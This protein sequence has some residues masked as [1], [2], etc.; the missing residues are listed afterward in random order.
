[1]AVGRITGPLL[2]KN[3]VRDGVDIAFDTDLLY[4][5][6]TNGRIGIKQSAPQYELDVSGT[7][8]ADRLIVNTA[9]IGLVT[10]ESSTSTNTGSTF[11]TLYGPIYIAPSGQ[12][13]I[14]LNANTYVEGSLHATGDITA[15]GDIRLGNSSTVDTLVI[16]AEV[17]SDIIPNL[18]TGTFVVTTG[19]STVFVTNTNIVSDFNIGSSSS[20]WNSGFFENIYGNTISPAG[21]STDITVFPNPVQLSNG[22][23]ANALTING[24]IRVYGGNPLG[25]APVVSNVLYVTMDGNDDNDGRAEDATRACRTVSGATQSPYYK[26]GTVIKVRSGHYYENNPI[27][28]LPYTAVIGDDLRTTFLE[29]INKTVDLFHV[30]SGVYI[31]QMNFLNLRRG[32]VTRYTPGGA[33]TYTTGAYCVAFPPRLDNPIDIYYSPYVQNCTNQSGPWMYDGTMF[34]PNQTVQIPNVVAHSTYPIGTDTIVVT[35]ITGTTEIIAVGDAVNGSGATISAGIPYAVVTAIKNT[36]VSFDNARILLEENK[37]FI[38]EEVLLYVDATNPGFVYDQVKCKRDVGLIL[39]AI[40]HDAILGGNEKSVEAGLSYYN[41]N[42]ILIPSEVSTTTNAIRYIETLANLVVGNEA[43]PI[44]YQ[45]VVPQYINTTTDGGTVARPNITAAVDTII[46]IIENWTVVENASSLLTANRSFIQAEVVAY[47]DNTFA[48]GFVYDKTKC[49]RDVGLIVES[50][51]LDLLY[52]GTSQSKFTGLQYWAQSSTAIPNEQTTTTNAINYAKTLAEQIVVNTTGVRYQSTVSQVLDA[53]NPGDITGLAAEFDL[54]TSIIANGTTGTT[55]LIVANGAVSASTATIN[56]YNLLVANR[57]F[58]QSEVVAYVEN[59][60]TSGFT[61]NEATCGRDVGYIIDSVAFDILHG[62]NRQAIQSGVYYYN[63]SGVTNA[64]A[65][66]LFQINATYEYL[67]TVI[68]NVVKATVIA[69]PYQTSVNQ[70]LGAGATQVE[71][72]ALTS[73]IDTI[74]NIIATGPSVAGTKEAI[75]LSASTDPNIS[76]AVA[77]LE[78]NKNFIRNEIIAYVDTTFPAV[79]FTYNKDF[80]YRDVGLIVDAVQYDIVHKSNTESIRAGKSYWN[81]ATSLIP[82]ESPQTLAAIAYAKELASSVVANDPVMPLQQTGGTIITQVINSQL[83]GGAIVDTKLRTAFDTISIIV[84][85]GISAAPATSNSTA[86]QFTIVLS[87]STVATKN[88]DTL[89][90]GTTYV[91]PLLDDEVPTEWSTST[92]VDRRLDPHGSGGGALVDGFA[93]S[94]KSPIQSFVFDAFTQITQGGN[95]IHIINNGYA[96][97]VSVFTIFC[98]IAVHCENG[99][100]CSI[101]NSNSNFGDLCLVAEGYG[102]REFGGTIYNPAIE[103][104]PLGFY[105]YNQEVEVFVPDAKNRPHIALVMEVIPP[106]TYIDYDLNEVQYVNEQG[107]P[108]FLSAAANSDVLTTSSYVITPIDT[109]GMAI[110]Q[111]IYI[112]DQYGN[113]EDAFGH[114][115]TTT[116][117]TITAI[118][119]QKIT[120]SEPITQ[121]GGEV[122]N[123]NYFNIYACG[124]AYYNILSSVKS[125]DKIPPGQSKIKGQEIQ[126]IAAIDYLKTLAQAVVSNDAIIIP[127]QTSTSQIIDLAL[128]GS[129]AVGA[130]GTECDIITGIILTGPTNAPTVKTSGVIPSGVADAVTL[131]NKNRKFIQDEV[132]AYVDNQYVLSG[133]VY[134]SVKCERDTGLIV[135]SLAFDL[136][137]EGS[138]QSTFAGLQYWTQTGPIDAIP[139]EITTTTN[140]VLHIKSIVSSIMLSSAVDPRPGNSTLQV[141]GTAGSTDTATAAFTNVGTVVTILSTGVGGIT[142]NIVSNGDASVDPLVTN[143]YDLLL[144]NKTFIIDDTIAWINGNNSGFNYNETTCRRDVG[145][146]IDCVAFDTLHGGNRQCIQAGAYYY[147]FSGSVSPIQN[148]TTQT[149]AAYNHI[150]SIVSNIITDTP[151]SSPYQS[152][153]TQTTGLTPGTGTEGVAVQ[154]L[155]DIITNIITNGPSVIT[156]KEPISLTPSSDVNVLNAYNLL[157]ANKDFIIAETTAFIEFNFAAP[158]VYNKRKCYRD[159]GLIIDALVADVVTGGNFRAVEAGST[160]YSKEGTYHLV[161]LEDNIRNPLLFVDGCSVNFYQRSYMSAS[162]YLFEYVGAGTQYGALPQVGKADPVQSKEVVQL[163]NGKVFFT[164]TDQNGDFRIGPTLVIS[165]ATGVLSGRTFEKSLFAQMTPFILAVEAGSSE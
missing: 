50:I 42:S 53:G 59:T 147:G 124:P 47:V 2:A 98:D 69:T 130:L 118:E 8:K 21:T 164:S 56:T 97:L 148:E 72:D 156:T 11:S 88:N 66:E 35:V 123:S 65:Q 79:G 128:D 120:L 89:Y 122:G 155:V 125:E 16:D 55:D 136:L 6:V 101:T 26:Q 121:G 117:T 29:A 133:F 63:F 4:L 134:D 93:P 127:A 37:N 64:V 3:L 84:E 107:Y 143:G 76:N 17:G 10:I 163:N 116:S 7:I 61:Y 44:T 102:A 57:E 34:V 13:N 87:T 30:N 91:F 126:T 154:G 19:S 28:L 150:R 73:F 105:P 77:L 68:T 153:V 58:I 85:H 106:E 51:G 33:G 36:D 9:T 99:G 71:A 119:Y 94:A 111:N 15:D 41:G 138:S 60:K 74:M 49:S 12:E 80:C 160:Y 144:A 141:F 114:R 24:D 75:G 31:A 43:V 131:L 137:Y 142:D 115:Y 95:G 1:M 45:A 151:V 82:G 70:V 140:A 46:D 100:I 78:S 22:F 159:V 40:T 67:K 162:G 54:I 146:I 27:E 135:D 92:N 20:Y 113:T 52:Q 39:D 32:E 112:R 158:F 165:Q 23:P 96:Q 129:S 145:Y 109:L 83:S 48:A 62:G 139:S 90:F 14:Y 161:L 132:V 81:G 25:T 86:S 110:G 18:S 157:L 152:V 103:N 108:G 149:N 5:D 38:K 104:Y